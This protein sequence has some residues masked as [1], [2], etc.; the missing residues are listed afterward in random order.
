MVRTKDPRLA[1]IKRYRRLLSQRLWKAHLE[2]RFVEEMKAM[3]REA[4][5]IFRE[6]AEMASTC[7][8][9][10]RGVARGSVRSRSRNGTRRH[11]G[12]A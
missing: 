7:R 1:R 8:G 6:D 9:S 12:K 2:G 10:E 4:T 3:G 5:A 11:R